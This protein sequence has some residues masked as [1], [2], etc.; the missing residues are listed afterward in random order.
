MEKNIKII[1]SLAKISSDDNKNVKGLQ[2]IVASIVQFPHKIN[3]KE[4]EILSDS[5][6]KNTLFFNHSN[7]TVIELGFW[8]DI[9]GKIVLINSK[10]LT[11][12]RI[13]I[14][15]FILAIIDGNNDRNNIVRDLLIQ[16]FGKYYKHYNKNYSKVGTAKS[17]FLPDNM[18]Y[19]NMIFIFNGILWSNII[20]LFRFLNI[21]IYGGNNSRRHLLSTVHTSLVK[22]LMLLN[23]MEIDPNIIYNSFKDIG[24]ANAKYDKQQLDYIRENIMMLAAQSARTTV[25]V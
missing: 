25:L 20:L 7:F 11:Y 16:S 13:N 3:I 17:L 18:G 19:N 21:S 6:Y 4:L 24:T 5:L 15:N 23:N 12:S 8:G 1:A 2:K 22:F 14:F 9:D 10:H